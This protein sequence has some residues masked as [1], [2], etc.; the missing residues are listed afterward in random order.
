LGRIRQV[1]LSFCRILRFRSKRAANHSYCSTHTNE[2][3]EISMQLMIDEGSPWMIS[4]IGNLHLLSTCSMASRRS[5]RT[6]LIELVEN[7]RNKS[8][9]HRHVS[10]YY[11]LQ[12][13][14]GLGLGL[15]SRRKVCLQVDLGRGLL[16][17]VKVAGVLLIRVAWTPEWPI[18]R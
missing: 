2:K 15:K 16:A 13:R 9:E 14:V 7:C 11:L 1:S 17:R 6:R 18:K 4:F 5:N 8:T 12:R 10:T 3:L